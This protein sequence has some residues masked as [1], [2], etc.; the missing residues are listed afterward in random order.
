MKNRTLYSTVLLGI[1]LMSG[2]KA[3]G[4]D[5]VYFNDGQYHR[6]DYLLD[7]QVYVDQNNPGL[8]T[9]VELTAGGGIAPGQGYGCIY[10]KNDSQVTVS[11]GEMGWS[12][13]GYDRSR[14]RLSDGYIRGDFFT[15]SVNKAYMS[16]GSVGYATAFGSGSFDISSG[17]IRGALETQGSTKAV[18]RGGT[19]AKVHCLDSSRIDIYGGTISGLIEAGYRIPPDQDSLI[20]FYGG[21]FMING[22]PVAQGAYA[23]SYI[24]TDTINQISG[25]LTDNSLLNTSFVIRGASD[26]LFIPEPCTFALLALGGLAVARRRK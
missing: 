7:A 5:M 16:G 18:V 1:I 15:T 17:I 14:V 2:I 13:E 24:S 25:I 3:W 4:F 11:G 6:I 23:S 22:H 26:I 19:I 9:H 21:D 12:L 20:T 10:A 8:G